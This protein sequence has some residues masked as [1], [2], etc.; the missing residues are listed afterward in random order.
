MS[1]VEIKQLQYRVNVDPREGHDL[2]RVLTSRFMMY[3]WMQARRNVRFLSKWNVKGYSVGSIKACI[4]IKGCPKQRGECPDNL[5]SFLELS[6]WIVYLGWACTKG[7]K[8]S[9]TKSM[10]RECILTQLHEGHFGADCT[11]IACTRDSV[12]WPQINKRYRTV[13]S[14]LV[15]ICQENSHAGIAKI[16]QLPREIP[17]APWSTI[18]SGSFLLWMSYSF[19]LVVDVDMTSMVSSGTGYLNRWNIVALVVNMH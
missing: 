12:Y 15:R 17:V 6:W 14:N 10:S 1:I 8:N 5:K 18:E 11:Q 16:L 19:M 13:S 4:I 9:N 3:F 7:Y 2:A